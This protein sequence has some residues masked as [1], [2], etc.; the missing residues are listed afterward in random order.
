MT[1]NNKEHFPKRKA[2][3]WSFSLMIFFI[4]SLN[5]DWQKDYLFWY[6]SISFV[7]LSYLISFKEIHFKNLGFLGWLFSF[8]FLGAFSSVWSL[9]PSIVWEVVTPLL[10][11]LFLLFLLQSSIYCGFDV[12][13]MFRNYFIATL[14]NSI[15]VILMI[16]LSQLGEIQ[17]GTQLLQGWNGNSIGFMAA[18]GALIGSY[19]IKKTNSKLAKT[20][21]ILS[22]AGLSLLTLY[23]GSRTAF[24]VLIGGICLFVFTSRPSKLVRNALIC[25]FVISVLF[26]IVMKT[27]SFYAVLG[28][29]LEGLFN[30]FSNEGEIDSS[31]KM[32]SIFIE[33]GKEWFSQKPLLGY[34]LNNYKIL[35]QS[36][37]GR[38]TYS[39]NNFIEMAVNLGVFGLIWYY[40]IYGYLLVKLLKR[41]K[42]NIF[43]AFML[44]LLL[45]ELVNHYG[46]VSY[47]DFYANL[48]L[49]LCF[50]A[51]KKEAKLKE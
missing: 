18:H 13:T 49:L 2:K 39:H 11:C 3:L 35:N 25:A 41:A 22:I 19:L 48:L 9:S 33:N 24:I 23:T 17:V 6:G 14:V 50:Y 4:I 51:T 15:Y 28:S 45:C 37:T 44:S 42:E 27:E 47:Y 8:I 30:L 1:S 46:N 38:L 16:D 10:V 20:F 26:Y 34:G 7:V 29:R 32:R 12:D 43:T 21:Y 31:A 40:S 5:F 36:A